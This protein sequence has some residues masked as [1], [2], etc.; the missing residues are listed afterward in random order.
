LV[1]AVSTGSRS[2]DDAV[3]AFL[4]DARARNCSP[5]TLAGYSGYLTG[6]RTRAFVEDYGI[7]TVADVTP[8]KIRSFQAELIEAG[9]SPGTAGTY[10]RVFR[11]FLGFCT[12]EGY[13]V[14]PESLLVGAP[15]EPV[16]EPETFTDSDERA[17]LEACESERDRLLIQFMIR[18][19]LRRSEVVNVRVDDIVDAPDGAFVRVRQGK[20]RKD[21][22]VPLDTPHDRFSRRLTRYIKVSRPADFQDPHLW[23]S[24]KKLPG[25]TEIA[26]LSVEGL[27]SLLERLSQKTGVHTNPHKF[28]HTFATRALAAGVDSLVLQRALGHT[29]LAMVNRYVHFQTSDLIRAWQARSD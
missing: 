20:G 25:A 1:R 29:T 14:P 26:P 4:R 17:L 9:L 24:I 18:T 6:P 22:I 5:T 3:G 10:H 13:G 15:F 11:N 16:T 21:R 28:R 19:G 12:R 27:K 8:E 7:R 2:W 23:L